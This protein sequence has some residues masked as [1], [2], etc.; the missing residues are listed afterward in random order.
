MFPLWFRTRTFQLWNLRAGGSRFALASPMED[1]KIV[2]CLELWKGS[3]I[4]Q[5]VSFWNRDFIR[6]PSASGKMVSRKLR[7]GFLRVDGIRTSREDHPI[8]ARGN[9]RS[10]NSSFVN[11]DLHY[12]ANRDAIVGQLV[13]TIESIVTAT[14]E[15]NNAII[16]HDRT[17]SHFSMNS[18]RILWDSFC[19]IRRLMVNARSSMRQWFIY[20]PSFT[21]IY[22][23]S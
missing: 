11:C 5:E 2:K 6:F 20:V 23:I 13:R 7:Y 8:T 16:S 4:R 19:L 21:F 14:W 9:D 18:N 1:C 15:C 10:E 3:S 22:S 12:R 17:D